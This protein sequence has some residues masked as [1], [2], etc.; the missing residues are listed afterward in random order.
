MQQL[1]AKSPSLVLP[2]EKSY[3]CWAGAI[4]ILFACHGY[5]FPERWL[6]KALFGEERNEGASTEQ[7]MF[8]LRHDFEDLHHRRFQA[9]CEKLRYNNGEETLNLIRYSL[10][11]G[12]PLLITNRNHAM[13]LVGIEYGP[14]ATNTSTIFISKAWV[15]DPACGCERMMSWSSFWNLY[16][17]IIVTVNPF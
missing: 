15:F 14:P 17:L 10:S 12:W 11:K 3:W 13:L 1:V 5:V 9:R 7:I 2:Q 16:D 4:E 8:I 6:V